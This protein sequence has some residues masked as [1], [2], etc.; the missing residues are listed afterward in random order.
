VVLGWARLRTRNHTLTQV[1][2]GVALA[3]GCVL[4][5]FRL[6]GLV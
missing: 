1:F 2:A 5:A 4:A 6:F 3:A